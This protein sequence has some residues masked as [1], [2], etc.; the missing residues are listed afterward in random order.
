VLAVLPFFVGCG[1]V[2][3]GSE[4][5]QE[6]VDQSALD[7]LIGQDDQSILLSLGR[8]DAAFYSEKLSYFIY[9]ALGKRY[10]M[11]FLP[12]PVWESV[13]PE[14]ELYCVLLEFDEENIFRHYR[15]KHHSKAMTNTSGC[16]YRFFTRKKLGT[17][18]VRYFYPIFTRE[19]SGTSAVRDFEEEDADAQMDLFWK[20]RLVDPPVAHRW[21]CRAADQGNSDASYHLGGSFRYGTNGLPIDPARAY[22][23]YSLAAQSGYRRA[24]IQR[25]ELLEEISANQLKEGQALLDIWQPGQCEQELVGLEPVKMP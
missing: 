8:P 14:R 10:Q 2:P 4:R 21:L 23:W 9:G 3:I 15:M 11:L 25:Q 12:F 18:T 16:A 20:M 22:V 6:L 1:F 19:E 7:S 13:A 5:P 24:K 17:F